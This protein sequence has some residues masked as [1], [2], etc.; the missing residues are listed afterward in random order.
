[1]SR[2]LVSVCIPVYN[3][4]HTIK[5]T[6][7]CVI[8][9]SYKNIEIIIV[10]N[11]SEDDT[12]NIVRSFEDERIKLYINDSNIGMAGNWN[13]CLEYASGEYIQLVCADDIILPECI[14][15]KA[16]MLDAHD[17]MYLVF[18]ASAIIDA[19][20]KVSMTRHEYKE[21]CVVDGKKLAKHSYHMKNLY[22]EPTNVMFRASALEKV[23]RF[24]LDSYYATDWDMWLRLSSLGC[25]GY[26]D[27]ELM[28]YRVTSS[29]QTSKIKFSRFLQDD[30]IM[31]QNMERYRCIDIDVTDRVIHRIMYIIR[32]I[33]RTMYMKLFI[34]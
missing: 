20:G 3:G 25:V 24:V 30:K 27:E 34:K 23:G 6:L 10:D 19:S 26:I 1:M 13:R 7:D 12:V 32:L 9:Q 28:Q 31:M 11:C 29:N 33:V 5:D 4:M 22:G 15:R 2:H 16:K 8:N 17:D 21:D 14:E 18:G